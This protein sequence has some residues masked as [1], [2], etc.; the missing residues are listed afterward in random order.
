MIRSLHL[1]I[2]F[3]FIIGIQGF[4]Q[5]NIRDSAIST[6][7]VQASYSF[8]IPAGDLSKRYVND[9]AI[10]LGYLYKTKTNWLF[11]ADGFFMFRDTIKESTI[12]DS[13]IT[14]DGNIIDGN[15]V[16][17]EV[18][19]YERGF[20]SGIKV[21]KLFPMVGPNKNSGIVVL[22]GIGLLQHK[23]R[24]ENKDNTAAQISD[25]Y[26]KGYDRLTNGLSAS[27]FLGY[28]HLGDSRLI[29]FYAGIELVEAWTQ[30]RRSY[31]FDLMGPDNTK[32]FD[33]LYTIKI[34]WIL[35]LYKRS[36]EAFYYN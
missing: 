36:P 13:I 3:V 14:S 7:L 28:M 26:R 12:L 9:N 31:N 5:V 29:N 17:A 15:G 19:L 27:Q 1:F 21:G 20:H 22:A 23:I 25:D 16:Y 18:H 35:P 8:Q 6:S 24:I 32:R 30:N 4:S 33:M 2:S 10:G 34:G 11:G